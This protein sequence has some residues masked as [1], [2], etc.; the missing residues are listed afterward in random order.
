[1]GVK[2]KQQSAWDDPITKWLG[3]FIAIA[4]IGSLLTL[5]SLFLMGFLS[6]DGGVTQNR[7]QRNLL[8]SEYRIH[9][10]STIDDWQNYLL[11][12]IAE[13]HLDRAESELQRAEALEFDVSR[14]QQLRFVEAALLDAHGDTEAAVDIL[15]E[16][17]ADS[18]D[19]YEYELEFGSHEMNWA[20]ARGIHDNV[21]HGLAHIIFFE[22]EHEN[23]Q[24]ALT[25]MDTLLEHYPHEAGMMIERAEAKVK[26]GDTEG[27]K[28]DFQTALR[29]MPHDERALEG[30]AQLEGTD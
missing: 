26:L 22:L 8:V 14:G 19:A 4:I 9:D 5:I 25:Y 23:Y 24:K 6:F 18:I 15:R 7:S 27:A 1:M 28:A 16:V 17:V 11:A 13:G 21:M 10:A 29:F 30:L 3:I 20:M 2:N 12:L